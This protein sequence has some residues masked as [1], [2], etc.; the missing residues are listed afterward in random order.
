MLVGRDR[1]VGELQSALPGTGTVGALYLIVGEPGIGKTRLAVE[2]GTLARSRGIRV[3]WG[4]CWEAAGAPPLWPWREAFESLGLAFPDPGAITASDPAEARFALFR[5]VAGALA[6]EATREPLLIVFEDLHAADRSTLMLLELVADQLRALPILMVGTYRDL[7][8]NLRADARDAIGRI[9]RVARVLQLPRLG[10][11]EVAALVR[12]TI[13]DAD[14]RLVDTLYETTHGNPLFVDELVREVRARGAGAD[15]PIPLGVREIIR[16]RLDLVTEQTRRVLEAGA[17]LGVEFDAAVID[18]VVPQATTTLDDAVTNGLLIRRGARLR[19]SHALYREALYHDLPRAQRQALH[20]AC[21]WALSATDAPLGET[22]HHLLEADRATFPSDTISTHVIH[23]PGIDALERWGVLERVL[24][25]GCPPMH[26]YAFD[27]GPFTICGAPGFDGRPAYA[28]RRLV[29]DKILVDAAAEAGA[30]V[31]EGFVVEDVIVEDGVVTCIRGHVKDG[32]TVTETARV[33]IGADGRNSVVAKTVAPERYNEKA[34]LLSSYFK[35]APGDK[36]LIV[37]VVGDELQLTDD[38]GTVL[39]T[40]VINDDD[41][42]LR[43]TDT[44]VTL[45]F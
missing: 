11:A 16:Q 21:A 34:P 29:L 18:R 24:A 44:C 15:V 45:A 41:S 27:F 39:T 3:S 37:G 10:R 2:L 26:T 13:A 36:D 32:P 35:L 1:E 42:T 14:E 43:V 4:R 12:D 8:A 6:R 40:I 30:E 33:V 5:E 38:A 25:S 9:N 31:R 7:E 22:A 23:P 20:R 17:V 19:F 28:P